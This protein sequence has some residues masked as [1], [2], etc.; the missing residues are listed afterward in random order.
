MFKQADIVNRMTEHE[1][2]FSAENVFWIE[3]RHVKRLIQSAPFHVE[4]P[5]P[6]L[7]GRH[8]AGVTR[9]TLVCSGCMSQMHEKFKSKDVHHDLNSS[10]II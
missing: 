5:P 1:Q 7:N 6:K 8:V 9:L 2:L 10:T 4:K 3:G